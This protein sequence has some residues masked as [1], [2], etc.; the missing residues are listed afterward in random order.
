MSLTPAQVEEWAETY[1]EA[2]LLPQQE[3]TAEHPLWWAV[4]RFMSVTEFEQA[5]DAWMA[6]LEVLNRTNSDEVLGVLAAGPLE[7]LIVYW[8]REFIERIEARAVE[9]PRFRHLLRGVWESRDL[10]KDSHDK[11]ECS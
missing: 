7:E 6:I 8:G 11:G 4:D 5:E 9:D 10:P 2:Q 3:L 1:I